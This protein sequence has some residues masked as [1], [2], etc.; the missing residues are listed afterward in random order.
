[1]RAELSS[2][3]WPW[4]WLDLKLPPVS[5]GIRASVSTEVMAND[6]DGGLPVGGGNRNLEEF[7]ISHTIFERKVDSIS[8]DLRRAIDTLE[9]CDRISEFGKTEHH[10]FVVLMFLR[11]VR[12]VRG[13]PDDMF[14]QLRLSFLS[15]MKEEFVIGGIV[16]AI[17][18]RHV[19]QPSF[20][21]NK[22][23]E[24]EC[25]VPCNNPPTKSNDYKGDDEVDHS[26]DSGETK[27][28]QEASAGDRGTFGREL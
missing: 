4:I 18:T 28:Y 23:F 5:S 7:R 17:Q 9:S 11:W 20:Q 15:P 2:F 24:F 14:N 1:M 6:D 13:E 19:F 8:N 25:L 21:S 26:S 27:V 12:M 16:I 22:T 3:F 10:L